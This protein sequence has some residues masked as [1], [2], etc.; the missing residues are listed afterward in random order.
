MELYDIYNIP[1]L[2]KSFTMTDGE[3]DK[4]QNKLKETQKQ[5]DEYQKNCKHEEVMINMIGEGSGFKVVKQC[6]KCN[7]IVGF[8]TQ[9]ETNNY[10][11]NIKK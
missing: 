10:L 5:I 6:K 3:M 8:P 9:D 11:N 1:N 7:S 4:L 2:K